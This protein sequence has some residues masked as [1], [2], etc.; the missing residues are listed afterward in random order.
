MS[1]GLFSGTGRA[2]NAV[3]EED[4]EIDKIE[5]QI[6]GGARL[7]SDQDLAPSSRFQLV[8]ASPSVDLSILK[9]SKLK[10]E[11]IAVQ[12]EF[13]PKTHRYEFSLGG[14]LATSTSFFKT[15]GINGRLSYYF[16]ETLG[17]ELQTTFLSSQTSQEVKD[18][19]ANRNN[20]GEIVTNLVSPRR[21]IGLD[22]YFSQVYGKAALE[23]QKIFPFELYE[24]IGIGSM[25]VS[26][27]R[28]STALHLG[29]GEVF[30][31]SRSAAWRAD[32][33]AYLYNTLD[34]NGNNSFT[35]TVLLTFGYGWFKPSVTYR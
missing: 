6:E 35:N 28:S 2:Q 19:A 11:T 27:G 8:P 5:L 3:T 14:A 18:L 23:S 15:Y 21:Y 26:G 22:G 7:Q 16:T 34:V 13:M 25:A 10:S 33:S 29:I 4:P 12:R 30:S 32:L 1:F 17:L 31:S 20:N 24:N 9:N